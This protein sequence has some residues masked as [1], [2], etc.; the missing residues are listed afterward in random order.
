[1]NT[2]PCWITGTSSIADRIEES[3]RDHL[4]AREGVPARRKVPAKPGPAH[5]AQALSH[6]L[7]YYNERRPHSSLG[8]RPRI[9][10]VHNLPRQD[11]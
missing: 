10:R 1:M 3:H 2:W 7:R 8:G 9:S 5:R 6:W 4:S 11:I